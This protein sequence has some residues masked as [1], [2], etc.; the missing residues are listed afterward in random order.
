MTT[1]FTWRENDVLPS[2]S[3]YNHDIAF[4][5]S[6]D[7]GVTWKNNAN[8]VVTDPGANLYANISSPDLTVVQIAPA[9]R[10]IDD[11]GHAVDPEGG[12]HGDEPS[13]CTAAELR[14]SQQRRFPPPLAESRRHL[15]KPGNAHPG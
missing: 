6:E 14:F 13:G 5:Y 10:M 8:A 1:S 12:I 11:Q 2:L 7:N 9:Y 15:A 3:T 4:M